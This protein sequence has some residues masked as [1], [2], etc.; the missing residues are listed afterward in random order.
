MDGTHQWD[1]CGLDNISN[2]ALVDGILGMECTQANIHIAL[3]AHT[4]T[5]TDS[6]CCSTASIHMD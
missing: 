3:R 5:G 2:A 6:E 1:S 4:A